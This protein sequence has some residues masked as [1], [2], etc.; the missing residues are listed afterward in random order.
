MKTWVLVLIYGVSAFG[1]GG[2][3]SI[4]FPN[5]ESCYKALEAMRITG[6]GQQAGEDDEQTI[7]YCKPKGRGE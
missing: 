1:A 2:F 5:E 4:E 6:Q 7:A 3:R